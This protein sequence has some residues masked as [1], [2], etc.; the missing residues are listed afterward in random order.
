[1]SNQFPVK[2]GE[3]VIVIA[4]KHKHG[5]KNGLASSGKVT[6]VDRSTST[7]TSPA[8]R[9]YLTPLESRLTRICRNRWTSAE[10]YQVSAW[11]TCI[12]TQIPRAR[13][14]GAVSSDAARCGS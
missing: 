2:V 4:G 14:C 3:E 8:G 6:S 11:S 10:T 1:M 7:V 12:V 5:N 9:L 13:P